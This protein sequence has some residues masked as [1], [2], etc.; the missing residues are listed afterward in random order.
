MDNNGPMRYATYARYS[1]DLQRQSS[2]EDQLRKCH[3]YGRSQGWIPAKDSSFADEAI[4]GVSTDRP[5]LQRMLQA[6]TSRC[7]QFDVILIDDTSR[8]SR[9]LSDAVQLFERLKF[10]GVRIIA[11]GQGIDT[12]SEQADVL[13]TVHG[14]VDSLYVKELAKKTHRGLEGAL[15]RGLHA[16]G[17]CYGYR[18]IPA[19][20]GGVKLVIEEKEAAVVRRIFKLSAD[21]MSLKSIATELNRERVSPPRPRA[22][23]RQASWCPTAIREMLRRELYIGRVIWNRSRFTKVPGTNRRVARPRPRSEWRISDRP[24]LRII[25]DELWQRVQAKNLRMA[26]LYGG[27]H[28]GLLNRSASSRNLLTGFLKCGLCGGNLVIVTGRQRR[29]AMYGCPQHFYRSTCSNDLK[30]RQAWLETQLLSD[31][32]QALLQPEAIDYALQEF[33]RQLDSASASAGKDRERK[34]AHKKE[35]EEQLQRLTTAVAQTG[36]SASLLQAIAERE[37][38]LAEVEKSLCQEGA[39]GGVH[40]EELRRF[41]VAR[42]SA[43]PELLSSDVARARSELARHID[44][45]KMTPTE[46]DGN[47]RYFCEGDW[48]LI[49]SLAA[50]GDVRMVAGGGFEPPTFGL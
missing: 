7:R 8:I 36:H 26:K 44:F 48:N 35:L 10:A 46:E 4:S 5:G 18:N 27:H 15:L 38:E 1:S 21:G 22:M 29:H 47:R 43:L 13:V 40:S 49:G 9:N 6:S 32:Q 42:L 33:Q 23:S 50:T 24:E 16:G 19:E 25:N 12:H 37:Q 30:V 20:G 14:L 41:A 34:K 2:I 28:Q 39:N 45:V 11:V 17:R 3:E 31:L